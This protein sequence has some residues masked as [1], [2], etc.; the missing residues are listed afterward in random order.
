[1]IGIGRGL[2]LQ[3][4]EEGA[5]LSLAARDANKLEEVASECRQQG[6]KAIAIPTDVT[7]KSQCSLLIERTIKE[8][9]RIDTLSNNAGLTCLPDSMK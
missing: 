4:A 1:M 8:Y 3:L 7:S 9:G 6:T 5:W 2:A